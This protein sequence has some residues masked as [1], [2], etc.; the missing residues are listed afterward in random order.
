MKLR[1]SAGKGFKPRIK[2]VACA[3]IGFQ[4]M[5][6]NCSIALWFELSFTF[7]FAF[8]VWLCSGWLGSLGS[9]LLSRSGSLPYWFSNM[10]LNA[11]L[12]PW[13]VRPITVTHV[14]IKNY[15]SLISRHIAHPFW[16]QVACIGLKKSS[17]VI[18]LRSNFA[19][20]F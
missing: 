10:L 15:T 8:S 1:T 6:A 14:L 20:H 4:Q 18:P 13:V 2:I 5:L 3:Q 9:L 11:S 7:C 19:K 16:Q 17:V 12:K